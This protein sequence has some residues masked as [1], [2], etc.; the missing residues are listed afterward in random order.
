MLYISNPLQQQQIKNSMIN[1][2]LLQLMS[3]RIQAV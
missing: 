3:M 2:E 1:V